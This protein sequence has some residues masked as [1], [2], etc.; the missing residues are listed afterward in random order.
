MSFE[1]MKSETLDVVDTL[2]ESAR[3][4]LDFLKDEA[5]KDLKSLLI[6]VGETVDVVLGSTVVVFGVAFMY[7]PEL[8]TSGAGGGRPGRRS[9]RAGAGGP[10]ASR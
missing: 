2:K 7:V 9:R 10:P 3:K 8:F 5:Q 1:K 4:S 6:G